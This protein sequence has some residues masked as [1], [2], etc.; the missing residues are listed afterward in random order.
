M[1]E[2]IPTFMAVTGCSDTATAKFYLESANNDVEQA[3]NT[4]MEGGGVPLGG[5]AADDQAGEAGNEGNQGGAFSVGMAEPKPGGAEEQRC[6]TC[7][8]KHARAIYRRTR[9]DLNKV[10][11][12]FI[13][14][15]T[16]FHSP[17][18]R[19]CDQ[20]RCRWYTGGPAGGSGQEVIAPGQSGDGRGNQA[21]EDLRQA[22]EPHA[23][24]GTSE[25]LA[26]ESSVFTGA[27][28]TL[29]GMLIKL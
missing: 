9:A 22:V 23:R 20:C 24:Q 8:S 19:S 6:C 10:L 1:D 3:I 16:P 17:V 21:F 2:H 26:E 15:A 14:I 11:S 12:T 25:D 18:Q 28:R 29:D 5:E 4:F 7:S 13:I 27:A